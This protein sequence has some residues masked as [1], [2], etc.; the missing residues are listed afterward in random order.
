MDKYIQ[1]YSPIAFILL[2]FIIA[3]F[4]IPFYDETHAFVISQLNFLEIFQLSRIEGHPILW[5]L[6]LKPFSS[7]NLY[8]YSLTIIN[9]IFAS[10]MI[11]IFWK[12]APF[13]NYIKFLLT[14]SYPFFQYFGIVSR[15]YTLGVLVIFLLCSFYKDSTKKPILYSILLVLCANISAIT[16]FIAFG[17]GVLFLYDIFKNKLEKKEVALISVIF[18]IGLILLVSQFCFLETPKMQSINAHS[19][20]LKHL[21]FP[22]NCLQFEH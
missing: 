6:I 5:Y 14:F 15:P 2:T 9:W 4:R 11:L 22:W 1:I 20:F 7:L 8:P 3:I 18:F 16:A 13:N 17:F 21:L 12:K 10:L 19:L